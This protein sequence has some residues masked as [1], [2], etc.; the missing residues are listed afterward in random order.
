M[1]LNDKLIGKRKLLRSVVEDDAEFILSLRLN[2]DLNGFINTTD[3]SV[4]KQ[5]Q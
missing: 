4:E 1:L 3:L 5:R 2:P